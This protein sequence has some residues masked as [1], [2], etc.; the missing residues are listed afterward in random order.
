M[1]KLD[2][3]RGFKTT[4]SK[5][6]RT[7]ELW[8]PSFREFM[9]TWVFRMPIHFQS[10]C[11]AHLGSVR[12]LPHSFDAPLQENGVGPQSYASRGLGLYSQGQGSIE[13]GHAANCQVV[14]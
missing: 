9:L 1:L 6:E 4:N 8:L 11:F 13:K 12:L 5:Q 10:S 14:S 3:F 2:R 7:Y